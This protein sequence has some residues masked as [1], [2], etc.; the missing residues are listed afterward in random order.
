MARLW[1]FVVAAS[2]RFYDD[3]CL[4]R[5]SALAYVSLLSLVPLLA[6]MFAVLKGLGVQR[7]IEPLLLS[8]LSLQPETTEAIIGFIDRINFNTLGAF[9]G[10]TLLLTVYSL[11]GSVEYCFNDI[12]RVPRARSYYQQLTHYFGVVL[13]TPFLLVSAVALTSS[14]QVWNVMRVVESSE[15]LTGAKGAILT[16]AP[17]AMN[18]VALA[19]LYSI[20]PNR[21]AYWPSILLGAVAAGIGWHVVQVAYVRLQIGMARYNAVYGALSQLP[22]TLVWQYVSWVIVLAGA[23]L[24]AVYE[25]G[26]Q[27]RRG[28]IARSSRLAIAMELLVRGARAFE[29]G[30]P[31]VSARDLAHDWRVP[32]PS[33]ADVAGWMVMRGWLAAVQ[34]AD[35]EYVLA[36][37]PPHI[38][39]GDM[40]ELVEDNVPP[41][42]QSSP[43]AEHM[44]KIL[45]TSHQEAWAH[46]TLA[47]ALSTNHTPPTNDLPPEPATARNIEPP[48]ASSS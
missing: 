16:L 28:D 30:T 23:E 7:R 29:S 46:F 6:V 27:A 14:I 13:L 21:R 19:V 4:M 33:V 9:A 22:V 41:P 18:I 17:I 8:R 37:S 3:N 24:A 38:R 5:A 15:V 31:S 12:W 10:V 44:L 2:V 34:D 35:G 25:F 45:T 20:M 26:A 47:D 48:L 42:L 32:F 11:L 1:R 43:E 39:L 36:V 40:A